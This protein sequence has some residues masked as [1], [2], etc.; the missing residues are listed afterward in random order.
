MTPGGG[1]ADEGP[2]PSV[3]RRASPHFRI[4]DPA[5]QTADPP[6]LLVHALSESRARCWYVSIDKAESSLCL[7][8]SN[9]PGLPNVSP[10]SGHA[11]RTMPQEGVLLFLKQAT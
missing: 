4:L 1:T 8:T 11:M 9:P 3:I 5:E 6:V 2:M 7:N 10:W